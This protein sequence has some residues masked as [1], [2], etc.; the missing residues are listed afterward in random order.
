MLEPVPGSMLTRLRAA[1]QR[2][3]AM[4]P[5]AGTV[6]LAV[7]DPDFVTPQPIVDAAI[8]ALTAG[9]THYADWNGEPDLRELIAEVENER[10]VIPYTAH[11]A[12]VGHG[13]NGVLMSAILAAVNPDDRVVVPEPT[14]SLYADLIALAG[15]VTDYVPLAADL[16]LD[17]A[18]IEA[19]LPGARLLI[20]CNPGNPTG[21]VFARSEL[22]AVAALA[23]R[24][25]VLV[26]VD[27][28]YADLVY[29]D[30]DFTRATSVEGWHDNLVVCQTLSKTFAMTG[31][32]LGWALAPGWLAEGMRQI[33]ATT[34]GALNTVVQ[35]AAIA[36]LRAGPD[37]AG[38]MLDVYAERRRFI[39]DRIAQIE[40]L[41]A[42]VPEGAFYVFAAYDAEIGSM[43]LAR[44]LL[45]RGVAVRP[46]REYG[47]SGEGHI[48]LSFAT[49]LRTIALGLDR[50]EKLLAELG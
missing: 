6:S 32:R 20:L 36:A 34:I 43:E 30:T 16:H 15:G 1:S 8:N 18:G 2:P 42:H 31:W 10:S 22:E 13:A 14:Y 29:D 41:H 4:I 50:I 35:K 3:A 44:M 19:A 24:H 9:F 27:E 33:N 7:G 28:A 11:E 26:I 39:V 49:D 38:Y 40:G 47:P 48:R 5:P 46:G 25:G 23:Q 17:L 37:V 21:A 45:A 12:V